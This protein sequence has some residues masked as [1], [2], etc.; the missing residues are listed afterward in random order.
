V[1]VP[2]S[3]GRTS[4]KFP[5][6]SLPLAS[7]ED[8]GVK[9]PINPLFLKPF[10]TFHTTTNLETFRVPKIL[11]NHPQPSSPKLA[12][13]KLSH[14]NH[15]HLKPSYII[16]AYLT[17]VNSKMSDEFTTP[18]TA[19]CKR[20]NSTTDREAADPS[21]QRNSIKHAIEEDAGQYAFNHLRSRVLKVDTILESSRDYPPADDAD[22]LGEERSDAIDD[23]KIVITSGAGAQQAALVGGFDSVKWERQQESRQQ[24]D[25]KNS[26]R[27]MK[28]LKKSLDSLA[29]RFNV[30]KWRRKHRKTRNSS[31]RMICSSSYPYLRLR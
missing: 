31:L 23:R 2:A 10:L 25:E 1:Q 16:T 22:D 29:R 9:E 5:G 18:T 28:S 30:A 3:W 14:L 21:K 20:R 15:E 24:S 11:H 17:H 12:H 8:K 4:F 27:K 13:A 26:S 19:Q 6:E 7:L